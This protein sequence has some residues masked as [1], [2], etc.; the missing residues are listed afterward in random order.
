ME[1]INKNK[2][3]VLLL[4][5]G[6]LAGLTACSYS[7]TGSSIPAHLKTISIPIFADRTGSGEFDLSQ[8]LTTQLTQKFIDDNTLTVGNRVNSNCVLEGVIASI[9]DTP[10]IVSG[11]TS[12]A[13]ETITA[14]RITIH[15]NASFKDLVKKQTVFEK[16]FSNYSDYI[17]K[18]DI[19]TVRKKAIEDA[20]DKITEDILL[21]V[22]S[23]W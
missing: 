18:G 7:F 5:A 10:T 19:T 11:T 17:V 12:G 4:V 23:N 14:R 21:G 6:S 22:V 20:I 13:Q 1:L 3:L 2:W 15:V 16:N 8:K 9:E